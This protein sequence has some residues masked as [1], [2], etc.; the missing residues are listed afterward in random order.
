MQRMREINNLLGS[1]IPVDARQN[2]YD[3]NILNRYNSAIHSELERVKREKYQAPSSAVD[4]ANL[5]LDDLDVISDSLA[6][7]VERGRPVELWI[8]QTEGVLQNSYSLIKNNKDYVVFNEGDEP[9]Y[10]A[11]KTTTRTRQLK[12]VIK[13]WQD[14]M[15]GKYKGMGFFYWIMISLLVDIGAFIFFDIAFRKEEY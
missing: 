5:Y 15:G 13:V 2:V 7:M 12:N 3:V 6:I 1:N 9:V 8:T 11:E 10:C 4:D 14:Y